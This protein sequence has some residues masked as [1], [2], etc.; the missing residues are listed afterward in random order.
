MCRSRRCTGCY[1]VISASERA[2]ICI[3]ETVD[4]RCLTSLVHLPRLAACGTI[5]H[6]M[7][8]GG[9]KVNHFLLL[10][11]FVLFTWL[12]LNERHRRWW[13]RLGC[14][15]ACMN[16]VPLDIAV[17]SKALINN[18]WHSDGTLFYQ[19]NARANL[20]TNSQV[21]RKKSCTLQFSNDVKLANAC[22]KNK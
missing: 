16:H 15:H 12:A 21:V 3:C 2:I 7:L 8:Y 19:S 4:I 10:V 13:S 5:I 18:A 22:T 17:M 14:Q 20:V 9:K 1:L 11:L 6:N